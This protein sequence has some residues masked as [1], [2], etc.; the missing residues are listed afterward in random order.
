MI[1]FMTTVHIHCT[2][3]SPSFTNLILGILVLVSQLVCSKHYG[4]EGVLD[5]LLPTTAK[6]FP[7]CV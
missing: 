4:G 7:C 1:A 5:S 2:K 3:D 6:M